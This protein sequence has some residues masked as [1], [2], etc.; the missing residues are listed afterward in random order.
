MPRSPRAALT[1]VGFAIATLVLYLGPGITRLGDICVP[2]CAQDPS[3]Y[4]WMFR[5]FA[6]AVL[7]GLNP[8]STPLVGGP[9]GTPL[10]WVTS[11][12]APALAGLPL[13]LLLGPQIS[14]NVI[15]LLSVALAGW[16]AYLLCFEVT[17]R[18][19]PSVGGGSLFL[20]SSYMTDELIHLNLVST[21]PVVLLAWLSLRFARGKVTSKRHVAGAAALLVVEFFTSTEVFTSMTFFAGLAVALVLFFNPSF[22]A[23]RGPALLR[24]MA[25][26]Y[27]VAGVVLAPFLLQALLRA[28]GAIAYAPE[29][30]SV[31]LPELFVPPMA[32]YLGRWAEGIQRAFGVWRAR[33]SDTS[34]SAG[35][36]LGLP[37]LFLLRHAW[38]ER[39]TY[40]AA[41]IAFIGIAIVFSFG[42]QIQVVGS[43]WI[44]G[45]YALLSHLPLLGLTF[46]KRFP[47]YSWIGIAVL[48]SLWLTQ[49]KP[50][51][52][53]ATFA[54]IL[55]GASLLIP[56]T[57]RLA[58]PTDVLPEYARPPF[59][60]TGDYRWFIGP[61]DS[62]LAL[63]VGRGQGIDWHVASDFG[64]RLAEA[65][66]GPYEGAW[67]D[68]ELLVWNVPPRNPAAIREVFE[69]RGVDW[70]A[71]SAGVSSPWRRVLSAVYGQ[72]P[73]SFGGIE[74]YGPRSEARAL[75]GGPSPEAQTL[76]R[77]GISAVT[78]GRL[79]D[80][81]ASLRRV[82]DLRPHHRHAH[83]ELGRIYVS[84]GDLDRAKAHFRAAL[85]ENPRFVAPLIDLARVLVSEGKLDEADL[86]Y[87]K[88][89][90]IRPSALSAS[91]R[92][93]IELLG[94]SGSEVRP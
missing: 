55:V 91:E 27:A 72:P 61:Q 89:F 46:P 7:H 87:L 33:P 44:P 65:Y 17:E 79:T 57:R 26:A 14:Y 10:Y 48:F 60:A 8:F 66:F 77:D 93:R 70:V 94:R 11:V 43:S 21:G 5:W 69:R 2:H 84:Y 64:F 18:H 76:F 36:Y 13:T 52:I 16:A 74:L 25:V 49:R 83:L 88:V 82:L 53:R 23:E 54:W 71:I 38:K 30:R 6:Y 63:G 81:A 1:F 90:R 29:T 80:A 4:V 3:L 59:F 92:A 35:G 41:L 68:A 22:R 31:D 24:G 15:S 51:A 86:Y 47:L 75:T 50:E 37:V 67:G 73:V 20:L 45:P 39:A 28:P 34:L 9:D 40:P 58:P 78:E 42:P 12:T 32:S 62:V 85:I 19:W 56:S